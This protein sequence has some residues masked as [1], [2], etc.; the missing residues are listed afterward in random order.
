MTKKDPVS[1]AVL[2]GWEGALP[3]D[4]IDVFM[5]LDTF[6]SKMELQKIDAEAKKNARK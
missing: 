3:K 6:F 1:F 4:M 2:I 5:E